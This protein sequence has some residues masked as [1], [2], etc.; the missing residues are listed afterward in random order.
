MDNKVISQQRAL[1][2]TPEKAR[3]IM[4]DINSMAQEEKIVKKQKY[5]AKKLAA[6]EKRMAAELA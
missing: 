6:T 5:D 2:L 1:W 3:F 4:I